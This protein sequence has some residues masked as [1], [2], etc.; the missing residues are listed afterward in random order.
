MTRRLRLF[1]PILFL[2][3][4]PAGVNAQNG[5]SVLIS[6]FASRGASSASDEFVELYNPAAYD[7][8]MSGWKL[9]YK[10]QSGSTWQDYGTLP[11]GAAIRAH[12]FY[13]LGSN[14]YAGA[15]AADFTWG[16]SGLADNGHVRILDAAAAEVDRVGYGTAVDPKISAAPSIGG[17]ATNNSV[18]RK[19]SISSTAATLAAGGAEE[20][21]GNMYNSNDNGADF[22]L[23]TNGRN[24]QNSASPIEPYSAD[25]TGSAYCTRKT[26]ASS[27][28]ANLQFVFRPSPA[29]PISEMKIV[30][31]AGFA[32]SR[33]ASAVLVDPHL[34]AT[35]AVLQDTILFQSLSFLADSVTI[36]LQIGSTPPAT[37]MSSFRFYTRGVDR[38]VEIQNSPS[39]LVLGPPV[40]ILEARENDPNG[41]PLKLGAYVTVEGFVT[42]ANQ[43]GGPSCMQDATAGIALFQS[44]FSQAVAIGDEVVITGRVEQYNGL[45]ELTDV[46]LH[47]KPSTGNRVQPVVV[48]VNDILYDGQNG[49]EQYESRL[50]RIDNVAVNTAVWTVSGAG[51]NYKINSGSDQ[52]DLRVDNDVDFANQPAPAGIFDVVGV[53]GQYKSAPPYIGAYQLMPRMKADIIA[54]GPRIVSP[55]EEKEIGPTEV[56]IGWTTQET[57]SSYVRYGKTGS[58]EIGAFGQADSAYAH[59]VRLRNLEPA[60]IYRSQAFSVAGPDTS[61]GPELIFS[62][63][64]LNSTGAIDLYFNKS[65]D[66]RLAVGPPARGN[67]NLASRLLDRIAAAKY[68][69][70]LCLYS[71]SGSVGADVATALLDAQ[72]RGVR[73]RVIAE[74]D[75]AN[76][77]A[78][79]RLRGAVPFITDAYDP[80]NAGAGLMHNKFFVI[81]ARD[82]SSDTDDRVITGSWNPTDDGTTSDAQNMIE[83][84]DQ[85]LAITYTAEFDE[86]WGSGAQTP[87]QSASRFGARKRD[88]TPHRFIIGGVPCESFFSPSDRT[89]SR[90][91]SALSN[92]SSSI[93]FCML[94]FTRSD[95]SGV[96]K[97]R[98]ASPAAVAV[99]GV[100]DNNVDTGNQYS[101]FASNGMDVLLKPAS[102]TGF[103]H[104]K[105]AIV[106]AERWDAGTLVIT[107]SHNWSSSAETINNEN[108]LIIHSGAVA[109][110][111]LQEFA[112]RYAEAG[113][114]AKIPTG[115]D[116]EP[117]GAPGAL[118]LPQN[119][120]NP[121]AERTMFAPAL[122]A[123]ATGAGWTLCLYDRLGRK[124]L[125]LT[126]RL[127]GGAPV[128]VGREE[129]PGPG[130]YYYRLSGPGVA[131]S[132]K[133]ILLR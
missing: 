108:T 102:M 29:D 110:Q 63:A 129:L 89:T 14:G 128:A 71:L 66:T 31:P 10:S 61:F 88:N 76:S 16:A 94:T 69:I 54:A 1:I 92:A 21:A 13:L 109:N 90:I 79:N 93:Q 91:A 38:L 30:V 41:V 72:A 118:L 52:M 105:Y 58:Y 56:A 65:V 74:N 19:A 123:G 81:D 46:T 122:P 17:S 73:V 119:Y 2:S 101:F 98:H 117:P 127:R 130:V 51:T 8:E 3:T 70:D 103:L 11:P 80:I 44:S 77:T 75:N 57:G 53:L 40:P 126:S 112:A 50:V 35:V 24:P 120:P 59:I 32:W 111:Y 5:A 62:S 107:G 23:Q 82:R 124:V 4:I 106:D 6:E 60:T 104:H 28:P 33:S 45:T 97:S 47:A 48:T 37:G 113:G 68:S 83:I 25:G 125:D 121:F 27:Q 85:A 34:S 43:F 12:G 78:M 22:L 87:S 131:A 36:T 49:S 95:L 133:M 26:I 55:P 114:T 84:Q 18:E 64:S 132:R 99:R 100:M 67:E 116:A 86:M 20:K 42:V 15:A 115:V 39:I 7:V 96:M 9:Q